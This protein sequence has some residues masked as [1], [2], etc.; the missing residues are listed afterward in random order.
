MVKQILILHIVILWFLET[1]QF[2]KKSFILAAFGLK[3]EQACLDR[4]K[5]EALNIETPAS[6]D[7]E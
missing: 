1:R 6:G 3:S 2:I 4:F 5:W 7:L